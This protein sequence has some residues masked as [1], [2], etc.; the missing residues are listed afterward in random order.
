MERFTDIT[1][2]K[3]NDLMYP[4]YILYHDIFLYVY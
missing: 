3:P 4:A 2:S 1:D